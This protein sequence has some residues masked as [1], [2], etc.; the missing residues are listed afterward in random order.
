[1]PSY[2]IPRV[3]FLLI[4]SS[5]VFADNYK[6]NNNNKNNNNLYLLSAY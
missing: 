4:S 2:P 6:D 1:M 5:E 3:L